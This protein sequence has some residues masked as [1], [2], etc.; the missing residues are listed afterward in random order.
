MK[1]ELTSKYKAYKAVHLPDRQW[2]NLSITKPPIW[3]SVDLRDGNQALIDPMTIPEKLEMFEFLITL[4]FKEIEIGFPSSSD[5]EFQFIRTLIERKLIPK[6]VTV[7]VLTQSRDHLIRRTFESIQGCE[8]AIV[9]LYNPTSELQ[10]RVV[11]G[12][13]QDGI[14]NIATDGT[15]LIKDIARRF[16][17]EIFLEYS[18]E[19]FTGTELEY[20]VDVCEA[21]MDIW[22]PDSKNRI[23]LNF[24][25][26]VEMSTP[27][28]YADRI[29]WINR[30]LKNRESVIIS[31]HTHNDRGTG[32]AASELGLLAGADRIEGTLFGNGERTGNADLVNIALNMYTQGIDPGLDLHDINS[33]IHI[34]EKCNKLKIA[35][36]HPY[37]GEL[38]YTAF[39]GSHQDA[40]R[41]G[42]LAQENSE[43]NLWEVPYLPIDPQD[44]GRT[45]ESI[46]RINSQSGKGGVAY[47]I[48]EECGYKLPRNMHP[49]FSRIIQ[50]ITDKTGKE[51]SPGEIFSAFENEYLSESGPFRFISVRET[52]HRKGYFE[53][54]YNKGSAT[55]MFSVKANGPLDTLR[56]IFLEKEKMSLNVKSFSEHS[57]NAGSD[58]QAIAYVEIADEN[59]E[60]YF[61]AGVSSN[62]TE[63]SCKAFFSA[64]NRLWKNY[65]Y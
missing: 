30:N 51:I 52:D 35:E 36:R 58:A 46:V 5:T 20:A 60:S 56:N 15:R 26:T 29:E 59:E 33:I 39:S 37:A 13:N 7:Q 28:I 16:G 24:P 44:L 23:I 57:L 8:K 19:S 1:N 42:M 65:K 49:E 50:K 2:P 54:V 47:V 64:V 31:L 41:K 9:H 10:R 63:A 11:F 61:G 45:Y 25:A 55:K 53:A 27:N 62:I 3:C 34:Y 48:E 40:I 22:E 14:K 6:D 4:G 17:S 38:V 21:V 12:L 32:V 43:N 18:P